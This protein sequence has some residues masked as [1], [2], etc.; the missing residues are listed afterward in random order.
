MLYI[1]LVLIGISL[2]IDAFSLSFSIGLNNSNFNKYKKY[3]LIV[4]IYHFLMPL[5]GY[6]FKNIVNSILF[7]PSKILF[8]TIILF[9]II[10][11]IIDKKDNI[12]VINPYIFGFTVSIDSFSIGIA[13][14]KNTILLGSIMFSVISSIFTFY[15]FNLSS[16]LKHNLNGK[17]KIISVIILLIILLY[18]ILK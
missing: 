5:F 10:G 6:M 12:K 2:S 4:G 7:I 15:G 3:A 18:N 13:L 11:I 14:S 17:S 1:E 9:I 16:K 8:I